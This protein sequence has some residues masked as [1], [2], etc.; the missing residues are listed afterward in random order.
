MTSSDAA[1]SMLVDAYRSGP[2]VLVLLKGRLVLG[3]CEAARERLHKLIQPEVDRIYLYMRELD[4][5]DS[6]GWGTMVGLKMAANRNR[7][8]L[9]FL[10]PNDRILDV[11]RISKLD[12]IFDLKG[13]KE[14]E[15]IRATLE[16]ADNLLWRDSPDEKQTRFA[17]EGGTGAIPAAVIAPNKEDPAASQEI[18]RLSRDAVEHL[19]LG[20]YQKAVDTYEKVLALEPS[21]LSAL[22]NLAVVYEKRP[23]WYDKAAHAWSEVLQLSERRGDTKHAE[24]ARK[25]LETLTKMRAS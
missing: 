16:K 24:R 17:T 20:D 25:H 21:D 11:F 3:N 5:V 19:K 8:K 2:D 9:V 4:Y 1:S 12:A 10:A 23:E 18:E 15:A 14:G 7:T 22:N 6:A 13:T